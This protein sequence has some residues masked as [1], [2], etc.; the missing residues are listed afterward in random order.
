MSNDESQAISTGLLIT[1]FIAV[2]TAGDAQDIVS[3]SISPLIRF[4]PPKSRTSREGK[5]DI[6]KAVNKSKIQELSAQYKDK[7]KF[8]SFFHEASNDPVSAA[9]E[10]DHVTGKTVL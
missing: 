3:Y 9:D 5:T 10:N 7:N 6:N 8:F 1:E 2:R 4:W